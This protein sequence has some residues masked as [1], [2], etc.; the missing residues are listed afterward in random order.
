M[1]YINEV[2]NALNNDENENILKKTSEQIEKEKYNILNELS[3]SNEH[4]TQI[5]DKLDEYI[6]VDEIPDIKYGSFIRWISLN[7]IENIKLTNGGIVCDVDICD[8][9][10][11]IKC[12]NFK[13]KIFSL[14]LSKSLIFRKLSHQEKVLL[15]V[16][17]YLNK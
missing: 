6:Y 8:N 2:L 1:S 10:V 12:K 13:N 15:S 3:I 4:I 9:G 16:S 14:H 7:N 17:D 11:I 5:L